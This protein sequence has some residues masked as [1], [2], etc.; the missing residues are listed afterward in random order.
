MSFAPVPSA[1]IMPAAVGPGALSDTAIR[2]LSVPAL[3]A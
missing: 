3:G 1:I 2:R